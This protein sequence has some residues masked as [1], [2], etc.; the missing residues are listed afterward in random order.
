MGFA[1]LPQKM[2][3]TNQVTRQN[4]TYTDHAAKKMHKSIGIN[5]LSQ[6]SSICCEKKLQKASFN[7]QRKIEKFTS[8][9]M[10]KKSRNS[11][12]DSFK[13]F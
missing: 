13:I 6:N 3:Y 7:Y 2:Q 5:K 12:V 1:N 11:S 8:R 10:E 9:S 4:A